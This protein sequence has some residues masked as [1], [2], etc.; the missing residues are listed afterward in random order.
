M[1]NRRGRLIVFEGIDGSGKGTQARLLMER[2]SE[3]GVPAAPIGFPQYDRS[4]FGKMV[5]TY[6]NGEYGEKVDPRLAAVLFA[7]DR[8]EAAGDIRRHL[9][10]G[11][12]AICDR[13][14]DSNK[15]HQAARMPAEERSAFLE[16]VDELEY[17]V[18]GLPRPD[19]TLF[20]HIPPDLAY[21]RIDR[22]PP[23]AHLKGETRDAHEADKAHLAAA[24]AVYLQLAA[25]L[26][27]N[28]GARIDC[29]EGDR[30]LG[31]D[32]IADRVQRAL[33]RS[34]VLAGL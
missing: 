30:E 23:R 1:S 17:G 6:L 28:A 25:L 12:L 33:E 3:Q 21:E 20:L 29:V 10:E 26:G 15:A 2:L 32:E 7:G 22:K 31:P 18:F 27:P 16:W 11:R 19:L 9:D 24:G 5:A 4:F 8:F 13:Y 34:G 14:V